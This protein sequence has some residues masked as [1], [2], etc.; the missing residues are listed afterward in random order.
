MSEM[1]QCVTDSHGEV[2]AEGGAAVLG[3]FGVSEVPNDA[4]FID[5]R[6]VNIV[7]HPKYLRK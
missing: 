7:T 3:M 5:T 1:W 2:R 6:E 4:E